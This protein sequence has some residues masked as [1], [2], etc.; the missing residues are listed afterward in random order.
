[1]VLNSLSY[2]NIGIQQIRCMLVVLV[3]LNLQF[4]SQ[5]IHPYPNWL[6]NLHC[7]HCWGM[8]Y[9]VSQSLDKGSVVRMVKS[10]VLTRLSWI[11]DKISYTGNVQVYFPFVSRP[12]LSTMGAFSNLYSNLGQ[13]ISLTWISAT[14]LATE[15][16]FPWKLKPFRPYRSW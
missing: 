8:P 6:V 10:G 11:R 16:S 15:A 12:A 3:L 7:I 14:L 5:L 4:I 1:M 2:V 9:T 13:F